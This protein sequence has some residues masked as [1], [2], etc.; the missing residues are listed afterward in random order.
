MP[1]VTELVSRV[2]EELEQAQRPGSQPLCSCVLG[3]EGPGAEE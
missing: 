3:T 1:K 2:G